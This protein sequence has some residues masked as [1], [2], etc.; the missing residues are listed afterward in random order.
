MDVVGNLLEVFL[1]EAA[2][3]EPASPKPYSTR[4]ES[5]LVAWA[6]V[7]VADNAEKPRMEGLKD[8]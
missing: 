5:T 6:G 3:S 7:H 4:L 1:F 8:T 2:G